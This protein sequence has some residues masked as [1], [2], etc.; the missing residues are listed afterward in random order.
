M[1]TAAICA[2]RE[3]SWRPSFPCGE[4]YDP[5]LG[6]YYLRARYYNPAT[7]RFMSRDPEDGK[8]DD[9][10]TLQKYLYAGG[11]PL[12]NTDPKGKATLAEF[13][14][15]LQ[16]ITLKIAVHS[17]HHYWVAP[18]IGKLWCIHLALYMISQDGL[19]WDQQIPLPWCSGGGPF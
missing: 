4:Q 5:D 3:V 14:I 8:A 6:L 18:I 10:A 1:T 7:G 11:D 13:K 17:A 12:N 9:P 19:L 2:M 16:N 15:N